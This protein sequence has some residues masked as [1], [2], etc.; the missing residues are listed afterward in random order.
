MLTLGA[1]ASCRLLT[2]P[3]ARKPAR[4]PAL[5][6][7][8]TA[9]APPAERELRQQFTAQL[10]HLDADLFEKTLQLLKGLPELAV[11][12]QIERELPHLIREVY[13]EH[14]PM[15]KEADME[16]W[17]Q[18]EARLREALMQ[19]TQAAKSTCQ[20]RLFAQDALQGLRLI[21]L[22]RE[23][24][25][26]R[27]IAHRPWQKSVKDC[28][29]KLVAGDYDWAHLAMH[30]WPERVAL[31]CADDRRLAIAHGLEDVFW[32]EGSNGKW[33]QRPV[34]RATV[35][36]LITERTLP[37]VK[38]ALKS[39][40][41]APAPSTGRGGGRRSAAPRRAAA[42]RRSSRE[43]AAT[44]TTVS[45]GGDASHRVREAIAGAADGVSKA[46]VMAATSIT[47]GQW[48]AAIK[49]LLADGSVRQTG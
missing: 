10:D 7:K 46:D 18:A 14:G 30:L 2:G 45:A 6:G 33:Q 17:R 35:S 21:D 37:A 11:L 4:T 12:P 25:L 28:W 29:D 22:T 44:G 43:T 3:E 32:V 36:R 31:K 39:L 49:A 41:E 19:F 9:V 5:L 13:G 40:L 27:L 1:P 38:D 15:F 47:D 48:N 24:P 34:D 23:A 16:Q 26:W 20:G 8:R 42:M